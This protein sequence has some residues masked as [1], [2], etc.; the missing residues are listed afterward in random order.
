MKPGGSLHAV[1]V[2]KH[3]ITVTSTARK[4]HQAVMILQDGKR[5]PFGGD[6][7]A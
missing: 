5:K 7:T 2:C 3:R 1:I 4:D 6:D